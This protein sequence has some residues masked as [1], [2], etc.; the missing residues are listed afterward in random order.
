[1]AKV[2]QYEEWDTALPHITFG[3]NTHVGTA[4]KVS[5]F[6]LAHG[7]QAR[8]PSKMDL[9]ERQAYSDDEETLSLVSA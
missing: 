6:E 3:L 4:T 8:E 7:F 2:V 5:P 9:S 1:M